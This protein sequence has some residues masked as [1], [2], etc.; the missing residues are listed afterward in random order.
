MTR[1][2]SKI[3]GDNIFNEQSSSLLSQGARRIKIK[4]ADCGDT[5]SLYYRGFTCLKC[6]LIF[7]EECAKKHFK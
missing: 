7:C 5:I 6:K 3:E 2:F 4:C 1:K